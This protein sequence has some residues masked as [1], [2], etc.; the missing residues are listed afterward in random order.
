MIVGP[1]NTCLIDVI[2]NIPFDEIFDRIYS[3]GG[4]TTEQRERTTREAL[5]E[6]VKGLDTEMH[7]NMYGYGFH[8]EESDIPRCVV[9]VAR[10]SSRND[11]SVE[12]RFQFAHDGTERPTFPFLGIPYMDKGSFQISLSS[13]I[14]SLDMNRL[15]KRLTDIIARTAREYVVSVYEQPASGQ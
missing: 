13:N 10:A 3:D 5:A 15:K 1:K 12:Y 6:V 4:I 14:P 7:D 8:S 9:F 2:E 11:I